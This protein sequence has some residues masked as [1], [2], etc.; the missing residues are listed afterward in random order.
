M[1]YQSPFVT[2]TRPLRVLVVGAGGTGSSLL[3]GLAQLAVALRSLGGLA[4]EVVVM[5]DD[6]VSSSNIG[7]QAFVPA[8]VGLPKCEVLV[9]RINLSFGL[10]WQAKVERLGI[11][12]N[13]RADVL[14]GCVDTRRARQ[15]IAAHWAANAAVGHQCLWVDCGNTQSAGQVVLGAMDVVELKPARSEPGKQWEA[16]VVEPRILLPSVAQL[17]PEAVNP[18]LDDADTG[19]SCSLPEALAK[20]DLFT[21][22]HMADAALNLLWQLLRH[23]GLDV[24]GAFINLQNMRSNPLPVNP[25]FW[26]RLGWV[27]KQP[28]KKRIV[29][30]KR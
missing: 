30:K 14:V 1:N 21:N 7:R 28:K 25:V 26:E 4:L 16:A 6:V 3:G 27:Q 13:L 22:R 15:A 29:A 23:G 12:T 8:D 24:H 18:Q 10:E 11:G 17:F 20:Q 5:D 19:P 9:N 2:L